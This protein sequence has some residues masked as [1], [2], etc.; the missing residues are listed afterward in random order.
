MMNGCGNDKIE[1][2]AWLDIRFS[3]K[4]GNEIFEGLPLINFYGKKSVTHFFEFV[5]KE[6]S[7]KQCNKRMEHIIENK[8]NKFRISM[9][10][11]Q[12]YISES[13]TDEELRYFR[14]IESMEFKCVVAREEPS[15][16]GEPLCVASYFEKF[17]RK[18]EPPNFDKL[19]KTQQAEISK[20]TLGEALM[21]TDGVN[22]FG[23]CQYD[24]IEMKPGK[25]FSK[26]YFIKDIPAR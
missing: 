24:V 16:I 26:K 20:K 11:Y 18:N 4:Y 25:Y 14:S 15:R 13:G 19:T 7:I 22:G 8:N 2:N 10:A 3:D 9:A 1:R 23:M 6:N 17:R 21:W 12:M 5:N